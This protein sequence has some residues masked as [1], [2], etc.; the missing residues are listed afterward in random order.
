MP[1]LCARWF[2]VLV[3]LL[4]AAGCCWLLRCCDGDSWAKDGGLGPR[5]GS[6][7]RG[8]GRRRGRVGSPERGTRGVLWG[9]HCTSGSVLYSTKAQ[10]RST[11]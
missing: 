8:H 7:G 6:G 9:V 3:L 1:R 2:G 5:A 10:V 11:K 4:A